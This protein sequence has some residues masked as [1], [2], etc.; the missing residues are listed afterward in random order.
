M[1][2]LTLIKQGKFQP[3][4]SEVSNPFSIIRAFALLF[5]DQLASKKIKFKLNENIYGNIMAVQAFK[6]MGILLDIDL[7]KQILFN[8]FTNACKFNKQEG[9]IKMNFQ[10]F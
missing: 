10:V 8:V 4:R 7:Y 2:N 1:L 6:K 3:K 5:E 9:I